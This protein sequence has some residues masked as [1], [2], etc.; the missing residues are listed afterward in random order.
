MNLNNNQLVL[1]DNIAYLQ[2]F[3]INIS[4][5]KESLQYL[6]LLMDI[7]MEIIPHQL[8]W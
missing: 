8:T 1:L 5:V 3:M 4:T 2:N 7:K 6:Q